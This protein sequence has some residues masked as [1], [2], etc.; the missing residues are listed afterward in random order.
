MKKIGMYIALAGIFAIVLNFMDRVP[1]IL[2]WIYSWG[3]NAAWAIKI[4]LVVIGG[5]LF[6]IGMKNEAQETPNDLELP[7]E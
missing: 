1:R 2:A 6:F 7:K 5:V 3:D 4:G